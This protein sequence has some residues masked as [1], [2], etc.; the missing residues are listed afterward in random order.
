[1]NPLYEDANIKLTF[2]SCVAIWPNV[3]IGDG[4][5][6]LFIKI[7]HIETQRGKSEFTWYIE[8]LRIKCMR[9]LHK[10]NVFMNFGFSAY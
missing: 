2:R 1:M 8:S 7:T 10:M 4:L 5:S 3:F 6:K 9:M